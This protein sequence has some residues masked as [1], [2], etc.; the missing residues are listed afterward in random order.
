MKKLN[1]VVTSGGTAEHI[2]DIRVLTNIS[3]G[4]LGALIAQTFLEHG[5]NVTYVAPESAVKPSDLYCYSFV[6]VTNTESVMEAMK[7][8]VPQADVV[9]HPMAISDFTF[10][11]E[12]A[13]KVSSDSS[14]ALIEHMRKTIR[15]TPKVISNFRKWNKDA[16]LVGF[17]FTSGKSSKEMVEIAKKLWEDNK[18][19]MV[20]AN[21]KKAIEKSGEHV[22][23]LLM[24][25]WEEVLRS[26]D[27]IAQSI[28]D[29]V[30]RLCSKTL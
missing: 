6:K 16:I 20:F 24:A 23:V 15:K 5:H 8:L 10:D 4:R 13:V 27:D 7:S 14:D 12:G 28:Y 11:Y 2:D 30:I 22:G 25:D 1:V 21:D 3:T 18:L 9:I 29:N 26:K 17:K 19:D